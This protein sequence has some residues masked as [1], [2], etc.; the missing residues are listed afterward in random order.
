MKDRIKRMLA[1]VM[2][3]VML[4][5][6]VPSI[7]ADFSVSASAVEVVEVGESS[8]AP[9]VVSESA[10]T[11]DEGGESTV[12][13]GPLKS[14]VNFFKDIAAIINAAIEFLKKYD[15]IKK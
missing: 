4:F 11:A 6:A 14:I 7:R 8:S 13:T 9:V 10:D 2:T 12:L 5:M 15:I 3:A 1:A